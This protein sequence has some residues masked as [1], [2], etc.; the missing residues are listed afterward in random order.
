[1][2]L[3]HSLDAFLASVQAHYTKPRLLSDGEHP[4]RGSCLPRGRGKTSDQKQLFGVL[5][6]ESREAVHTNLLKEVYQS[7]GACYLAI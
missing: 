5:H 6:R 1:M 2:S 7:E 3:E 4:A